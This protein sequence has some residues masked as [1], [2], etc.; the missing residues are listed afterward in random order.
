MYK[1]GRAEETIIESTR[2]LYELTKT[3]NINDPEQVKLAIREKTTWNNRTKST[4]ASSYTAYLRF[5]DKTWTPPK[6]IIQEKIYFIPTE[7]EIDS[8]IASAGKTIAPLLQFLKET[9]ARIGEAANVEWKDI[10][11]EQ[12]TVSINHP[13]KGSLPRILRFS[14]KLKG[15]INNI[16]K[17]TPKPFLRTCKSK[18]GLRVTFNQM[19]TRTATKL[20]NPRLNQISFHTFRHW[21][22]TTDYYRFR[23]PIH[24][25]A[26]LGHK[27][28][29]MTD[30]YIHIV[31]TLYHDDSGEWTSKAAQTKEEAM[32]LIDAGFTYVQTI[33]DPTGTWH[34]YRKRK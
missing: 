18:K 6:I 34:I 1:N 2:R 13:E 7:Q 31:E 33:T 10:D 11:L 25:R 24:I 15:M 23:D 21:K 30:R 32:K 19:R 28:A 16:P 29:T 5:K 27:S 3:C 14:D 8:L 17:N 20:N 12:K 22:A 4:A 9:G 26:V